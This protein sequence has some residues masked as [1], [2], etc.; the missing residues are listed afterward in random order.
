VARRSTATALRDAKPGTVAADAGSLHIAI[1]GHI[2]HGKSTLIGRLLHE[3][4]ALP[5]GK[6]EAVEA[7]CR[8]R[9]VPFEWAFVTDALQTERDQG[10]TTD[11]SHIRFSTPSRGYVFVDAP[12]H[13]EFLKNM[14]SGAAL[15]DAALLVIDAAEGVHEQSR[16]HGFLVHLLGIRQVVV[17]V[18]KMDA[19]G[20]DAARFADIER[21]YRTYLEEVGIS[22]THI[23]PVSAREGDNIAARS[24][25]TSWYAGPSVLEAIER[26]AAQAP[27]RELPLRMP[28]QDVYRFDD[29][30]IIAGRIESG[31][32]RVGDRLMFSP[33]N[34]TAVVRSIEAW[35]VP[36]HLF[37][38]HAGQ[39]VGFTLEDQIFV[40]RGEVASHEDHAPIETDVFRGRLFW[41]GAAPLEAGQRYTLKLGTLQTPVTAERIEKVIETNDLSSRAADRIQRDAVGEVI[42]RSRAL[43]ALDPHADN[44][45]TGRFVLVDGNDVVAGGLIDMDGYPDQRPLL[46]VRSTNVTAVEHRVTEPMRASRSGHAGGVIWFT[47]L[48]GAGK[49][50]LAIELEQ[51][52]FTRG[53]QVYV[54]DGDNVRRGLNANLSFSPEDRAENIRR[55]G[56][57]AA[58]FADAGMI[59]ITAFISPYRSDRDR[60]RAA[61]GDRFREV[62]IKAP[63]AECERRDPKGLY[64]KARSGA[65]P[66]FTGVSAPYE[67]PETA[68]L[69]IDT[70][71]QGVEESVRALIEFVEREFELRAR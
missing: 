33:S 13:R 64:A 46:T 16:R 8:R 66:E 37:S 68:D 21:E 15:S 70:E 9:G 63:L 47:G 10:A 23:I 58:L 32:L 18:N 49:S 31:R 60:A 50:T 7:M 65:I 36:E 34:K 28:V 39:S 53:Y 1:V 55:V 29:R 57:V 62:H 6:L 19:V 3:V 4:G 22:P 25:R 14:I 52:L 2:D 24:A 44:P 48:S 17:A 26:F 67:E 38:A 59:V 40:D 42:L 5:D 71:R 45:R 56:E 69:I 20:Y 61:A 51:R 11:V 35:N 54:L 41:L 43:L 30:R 12:G 27:L